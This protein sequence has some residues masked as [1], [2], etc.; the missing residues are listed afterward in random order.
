[1]R[2]SMALGGGGSGIDG[3]EETGGVVMVVQETG[4]TDEK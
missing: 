2:T 4:E 3:T 1:M